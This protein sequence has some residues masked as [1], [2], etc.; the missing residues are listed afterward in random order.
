MGKLQRLYREK[1]T[2]QQV[3]DA[4]NRLARRLYASLGYEVEEGYRFDKA[5]HPQEQGMWNMAAIAFDEIEGT[6]IE[7]ALAQVSD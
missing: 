5:I 4:A 3:V 1:R 7:D 6:D 2:E